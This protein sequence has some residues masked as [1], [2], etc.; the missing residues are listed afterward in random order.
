MYEKCCPQSGGL[1][2]TGP[3]LGAWMSGQGRLSYPAFP[4]ISV[5]RWEG[6][7]VV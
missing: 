2:R 4:G 3:F 1:K 5:G 6:G 7:E